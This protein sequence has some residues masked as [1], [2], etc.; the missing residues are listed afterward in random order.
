MNGLR[1][2]LKRWYLYIPALALVVAVGVY[3]IP[4]AIVQLSLAMVLVDRGDWEYHGLPNGFFVFCPNSVTITIESH[5]TYIGVVGYVYKLAWDDRYIYA[6][7]IM[8]MEHGRRTFDDD[9]ADYY[10]LDTQELTTTMAIS[11]EEFRTRCRA[12]IGVDE[13]EW[14]RSTDLAK[15]AREQASNA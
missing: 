1:K 2:Y 13:P 8:D 3:A 10:I 11:R 7:R 14:T 5:D 15:P 9:T 12:L 4:R 6:A